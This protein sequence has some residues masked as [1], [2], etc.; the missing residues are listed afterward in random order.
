[1]KI[2]IHIDFNDA[3]RDAI[4]ASDYATAKLAE[5]N[6]DADR[7]PDVALL[8]APDR[9]ALRQSWR[10]AAYLLAARYA[11]HVTH[12]DA[13]ENRCHLDLEL[14]DHRRATLDNTLTDAVRSFLAHAITSRWFELC[15]LAELA[16]GETEKQAGLLP[17][18]DRAI[19]HKA[20]PSR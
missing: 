10:D 2:Q 19:Y 12:Y 7:L 13:D 17:V 15:N 4:L 18:I 14:S 8:Q 9:D 3:F 11:H 6:P 20:P 5:I 16:K 1:M